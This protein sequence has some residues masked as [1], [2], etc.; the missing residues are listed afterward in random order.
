[1]PIII[2]HNAMRVFIILF[3]SPSWPNAFYIV[4]GSMLNDVKRF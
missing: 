3:L 2:M 4:E 1:M